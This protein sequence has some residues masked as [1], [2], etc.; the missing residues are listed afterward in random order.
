[1]C[2]VT[3]H[4]DGA[5]ILGENGA[6]QYEW[7]ILVGSRRIRTAVALSVEKWSQTTH[8][9]FVGWLFLGNKALN[10]SDLLS[11][12]ERSE[13]DVSNCKIVRGVAAADLWEA[14]FWND[15]RFGVYGM[16]KILILTDECRSF[17]LQV[18]SL[19]ECHTL[20]TQEE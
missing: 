19:P 6:K 13:P 1:M 10:S 9:P 7:M 8:H 4:T 16:G 17:N 12:V 2:Q 15:F 11:I 18:L 14:E 5:L 3:Q 20:T